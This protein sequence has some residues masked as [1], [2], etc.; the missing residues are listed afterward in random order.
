MLNELN[1]IEW[2]KLYR[3]DDTLH[4]KVKDMLLAMLSSIILREVLFP[5]CH[6]MEALL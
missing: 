3:T 6:F 1:Y 4:L 5:C 2:T